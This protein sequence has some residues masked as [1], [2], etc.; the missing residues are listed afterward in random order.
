[1]T[2]ERTPV[3][4][5]SDTVLKNGS[6]STSL[7]KSLLST[8]E[9]DLMNSCREDMLKTVWLEKFLRYWKL[10]GDVLILRFEDK[11]YDNWHQTS[12]DINRN[13]AP[14][15]LSVRMMSRDKNNRSFQLGN[16]LSQV[17]RGMHVLS[18]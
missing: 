8:E 9:K 10:S 11:K 12:Y 15:G 14:M 17:A 1:M 16:V 5:Q 6:R 4:Q 2:W 18:W 7:L 13:G 3:T